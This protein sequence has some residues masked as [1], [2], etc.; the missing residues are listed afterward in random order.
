[1]M[2]SA[3]LKE[4]ALNVLSFHRFFLFSAQ[5]PFCIELKRRR[6]VC[7]CMLLSALCFS[8]LVN[9]RELVQ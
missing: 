7:L 1:M 3:E 4:I 6:R 5:L 2:L 8:L 9:T